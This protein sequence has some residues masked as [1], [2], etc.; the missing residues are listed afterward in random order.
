MKIRG[1][2]VELSEI[3]AQLH[4]L[5]GI[6]EAL[7][8]AD[9]LSRVGNAIDVEIELAHFYTVPTIVY[10]AC[11]IQGEGVD[12]A[13]STPQPQQDIDVALRMLGGF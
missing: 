5:R 6:S 2:R 8:A 13:E 9:L 1:F 4:A 3:E 10:L 7:K 12:S 11:L